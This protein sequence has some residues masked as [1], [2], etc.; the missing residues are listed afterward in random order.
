MTY[1]CEFQ[2]STDKT[3]FNAIVAD[4]G[5]SGTLTYICNIVLEIAA[6]NSKNHSRKHETPIET[7]FFHESEQKTGGNVS[8]RS[9]R[10]DQGVV[11]TVEDS[12]S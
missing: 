8:S 10:H 1:I 4:L 6:S 3:Q 5:S 12:C 11:D 7:V 2:H 9:K